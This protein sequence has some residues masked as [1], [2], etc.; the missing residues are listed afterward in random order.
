MKGGGRASGKGETNP[1]VFLGATLR[2]AYHLDGT[3]LEDWRL[4]V[5]H[6]RAHSLN[7]HSPIE[8]MREEIRVDFGCI[9]G[10]G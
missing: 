4:E 2:T 7:D 5:I 3:F 10:V 8:G 1:D 9:G 6:Q